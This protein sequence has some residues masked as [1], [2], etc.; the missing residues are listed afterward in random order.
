MT[1]REILK[2]SKADSSLAFKYK[3][4][5]KQIVDLNGIRELLPNDHLLFRTQKEVLEFCENYKVEKYDLQRNT[6]KRIY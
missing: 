4:F 1:S 5:L 3:L 2:N 6:Q